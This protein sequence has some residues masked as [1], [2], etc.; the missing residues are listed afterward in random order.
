MIT[1]TWVGKTALIGAVGGLL[2]LGACAGNKPQASP[3]G[4]G[5]EDH[6]QHAL[7]DRDSRNNE[8]P[9]L[10]IKQRWADEQKGNRQAQSPEAAAPLDMTNRHLSKT[11]AFDPALAERVKQVPGVKE[12]TVLLTEVNGYVA[13]VMDGH[14]AETEADPDM[15][16]YPITSKGGIGLFGTDKGATRVNWTDPG[17]LTDGKTAEITKVVGDRAHTGLQRVYVSAN[18]N[19]VQRIRFYAKEERERGSFSDY[20]NEFNTMVQRVF[21]NDVNTR[22]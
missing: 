22:K 4:G 20:F 19:F 12:A 17:G 18:P 6:R 2:L 1:N 13:V 9:S 21:P 16:N 7:Y 10:G 15:M 11:M 14:A 8:D 5:L 3:P